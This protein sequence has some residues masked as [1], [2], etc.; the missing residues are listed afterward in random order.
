MPIEYEM[1]YLYNITLNAIARY[2]EDYYCSSWYHGIENI[3]LDHLQKGDRSVL[4][5]FNYYERICMNN[6]LKRGYWV[7]WTDD[8]VIL[9]NLNKG[10]V[11]ELEW[12]DTKPIPNGAD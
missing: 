8:G 1:R 12:D 11:K 6:L 7:K 5:Y 3:V 9:V 10:V 2:S 4:D